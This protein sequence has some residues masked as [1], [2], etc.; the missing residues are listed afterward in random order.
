MSLLK[1]LYTQEGD[2]I[3]L[4]KQLEEDFLNREPYKF[5]LKS[6]LAMKVLKYCCCCLRHTKLYKDHKK[7]ENKY[8]LA[9]QRLAKEIDISNFIKS[10]RVEK[11]FSSLTLRKNQAQMV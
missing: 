4:S 10:S 11:F 3:K 9:T 1:K 6:Y 8:E 2:K 5:S 7:L